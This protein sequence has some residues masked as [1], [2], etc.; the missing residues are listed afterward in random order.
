[1]SAPLL[2]SMISAVTNGHV[3]YNAARAPGGALPP[4]GGCVDSQGD[5]VRACVLARECATLVRVGV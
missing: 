3:A 2:V 5:Q 1:M 4:P